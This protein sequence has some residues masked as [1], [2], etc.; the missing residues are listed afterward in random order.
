[1]YIVITPNCMSVFRGRREERVVEI[2][3]R[4]SVSDAGVV[5]S[6]G[7]P[8][9]AIGGEGVNLH[10]KRVKIAYLVARAFVPN[11]ELRKW[12]RHKNGDRRDNRAE[13]LEWSDEKEV[14]RRG[15][16]PAERWCK[17][18]D[19]D[20]EVVGI[21]GSIAEASEATGVRVSAIRACLNG[22]QKRAGGLLWRNL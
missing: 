2:D 20:G 17:A 9:E 11:A 22:Y 1:M 14:W 19:L 7:M 21:W 10:G 5:Y 15:R 13:N 8:L 3:S 16:K 6:G 18:W 12:V 4:Y